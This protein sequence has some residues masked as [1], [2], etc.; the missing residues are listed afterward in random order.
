MISGTWF[1]QNGVAGACGTVHSDNDFIVALDSAIYGDLG[2][3]SK[4]CGKS[5]TITNVATGH[6]ETAVVADACPTC[7]SSGSLDM[8]EGLFKAIA[9]DLGIG[10][11]K[12]KSS[13]YYSV[14]VTVADTASPVKWQFD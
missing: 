10:L 8:S 5:L 14:D 4:Y 12:S 11:F 9:G 1:T 6:Q 3:T 2:A 13:V 7:D